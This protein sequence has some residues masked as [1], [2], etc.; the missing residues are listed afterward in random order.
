MLTHLKL[1]S[2]ENLFKFICSTYLFYVNKLGNIQQLCT[3]KIT[4]ANSNILVMYGSYT[5]STNN[6]VFQVTKW[7][8]TLSFCREITGIKFFLNKKLFETEVQ[9]K[10][11]KQ[12]FKSHQNKHIHSKDM[13]IS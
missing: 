11:S 9:M 5:K 12:T 8:S 6:L 4:F 7:H 1:P 3:E 10:V 2:T 13:C